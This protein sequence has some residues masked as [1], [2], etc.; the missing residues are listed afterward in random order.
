[1]KRSSCRCSRRTALLATVSLAACARPTS[2]CGARTGPDASAAGAPV[3]PCASLS[4]VV[5]RWP[6]AGSL[7]L[8]GASGGA[9]GGAR[10]AAGREAVD[11]A[12]VTSSTE[13]AP[14]PLW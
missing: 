14:K 3:P 5:N 6:R 13:S 12:V 9:A 2:G 11:D 8:G 7:F 4:S 1:M 10:A